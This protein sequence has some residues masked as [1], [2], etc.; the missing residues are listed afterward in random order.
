[1][2]F[3]ESPYAFHTIGSTMAVNALNYAKVRGFPKREA[4]EDFYLLNKLAKVRAVIELT[5]DDDCRPIEIESRRS[6]RVPFGT[7]AA[8]NK[9]TSLSDPVKDYR[10][11]NPVVFLLL[12][13]W[14]QA[15]PAIWLSKSEDL[16]QAVFSDQNSTDELDGHLPLLVSCLRDIGT[17]KA[18]SHAFRQSKDQQQF[19]RQMHTWFD[20]FQILKLIQG[21]RYKHLYLLPYSEIII[22][23]IYRKILKHDHELL[24][25][26]QDLGMKEA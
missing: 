15:L 1:M 17:E 26:H 19:E 14:L 20:A 21:I 16:N 24:T 8:V 2:K 3:A 18:L 5:Q 11:Y 9:I 23:T 6:D 12:K 25:Y 10:F 7:G 4:G 13:R 22:N